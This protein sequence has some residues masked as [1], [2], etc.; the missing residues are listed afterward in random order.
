MTLHKQKRPPGGNPGGEK[1]IAL[2]ARIHF[3]YTEFPAVRQGKA[4]PFD[5]HT[6][7]GRGRL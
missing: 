2:S 5:P 4:H 7:W 6:L 3:Q 1:D